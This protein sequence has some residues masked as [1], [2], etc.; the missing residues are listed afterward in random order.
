[1]KNQRK[2]ILIVNRYFHLGGIQSSLINMANELCK[3]YDV[4]VLA[5]YPEGILKKRLDPK[6]GVIKAS[7][8]I[9]AMGM[10][11]GEA[12]RSNN[13]FLFMFRIVGSVWARVFDNRLPIFIATQ[14]LQW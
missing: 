3:E 4:D 1:M 5:Y 9:C 10:S 7:W 8:P 11:P 12:L 2:R 13:P 14:F 6:V